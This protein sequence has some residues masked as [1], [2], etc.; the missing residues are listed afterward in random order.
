[1]SYPVT[2][3]PRHRRTRRRQRQSRERAQTVRAEDVRIP[4]MSYILYPSEPLRAVFSTVP[5]VRHV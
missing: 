3:H 5:R 2:V 4:A 1:M